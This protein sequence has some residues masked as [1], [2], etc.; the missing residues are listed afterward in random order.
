VKF[1]EE[2]RDCLEYIDKYWNK[3]I[4]KPS[5]L[6]LEYSYIN[7]PALLP[8][9]NS[10]PHI[11]TIP[12]TYFV[13]NIGHHKRIYYWDSFFMFK[14]LIGTKRQDITKKMVNNFIYLYEKYQIIPNF[15]APASINRSQ[16]PFLSSMI[17]DAYLTPLST[18]KN[19]R[20]HTGISSHIYKLKNKSWLKKAISIAKKEYETVWIDSENLYNHHVQGYGLSRYGDR[21]I[22]YAHS[23]ELESG[24]DMTSRFYNRCDQFLP[25]DLN[26]YLYK[27]EK[28]FAF[29]AKLLNDHKEEK[30]WN[31]RAET[32]KNEISKYMWDDDEKFFFDYGYEYQLV[33]HF[34]SLASYTPMWAGLAT[35]T[36]AKHMV[37]RLDKF[38]TDY[39]LTISAKE[40]LAKPINLAK[41]QRRYHPAINEIIQPK[42]WDYPNIW[43]P[44]EYLTVIG[45]LKYGFTS[46]AKRIMEKSIKAHATLFRKYHTFFEKING[47][48]GLPGSGALYGD[49]DGFGWTNAAF[50]RYVMILD[51]LET[52]KSIYTLPKPKTAPF[53]LAILH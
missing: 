53:E 42:Q 49:Q 38:E 21:D 7:I 19:H 9:K 31:D 24:W 36:Q 26:C 35:P 18:H 15:N 10:N 50:Y 4:F 1:A 8:E 28:D 3:I 52:M 20:Y 30:L 13:P 44:L 25:V 43:S 2:Y 23:S 48:T 45:L 29:V 14:G 17:L 47:K 32:R 46:H 22:G 16:P 34:F 39:G 51:Q 5:R 37:E 12:Y 6:R 11:I 33:S 41:I 27:Y 40:S